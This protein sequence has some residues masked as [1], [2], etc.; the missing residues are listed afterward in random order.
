M[1]RLLL[2]KF[3]PRTTES[4][5]C[6]PVV[7]GLLATAVVFFF[8]IEGVSL[9]LMGEEKE[10]K[11]VIKV[12]AYVDRNIITIGDKVTY[13]LEVKADKNVEVDLPQILP[14]SLGGLAIR[15]FGSL[16]KKRWRKNIYKQWYKLDTYTTGNYTIPEL[17]VK[18][19]RK[20][21]EW[22]EIKSN[23]VIIKVQ[24]LL[25]KAGGKVKLRDIAGPVGFPVNRCIY[26][27]MILGV[28]LGGI[29]LGVWKIMRDKRRKQQ[30]VKSPKP[31]YE[32]AYELLAELKSKD[33]LTKGKI[34][35]YY[36][37]LSDIVRKYIERRFNLR[38][39][40]MTTEEFLTSVKD[41]EL[42]SSE[43]KK[44]VGDFLS[45]CDLVKFAK[46]QPLREEIELSFAS[47]K[48]LVDQTKESD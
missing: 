2:N 44:L 6:K 4:H 1:N 10:R 32:V 24:S 5:G 41:N 38:A 37:E 14:Q 13:T 35:E 9:P 3:L 25:S 42:L 47:A 39:P 26:I 21:E 27:L 36:T 22:Q 28:V 48:K 30:E 17:V 15:D 12:R 45:H 11:G 29:G 23:S 43:H 31:A 7:R 46:Y 40:E 18:Y 20:G 19:R 16:Q 34:K 33:Y 8:F